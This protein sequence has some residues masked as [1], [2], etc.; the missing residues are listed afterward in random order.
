MDPELL[1]T[2]ELPE[3]ARLLIEQGEQSLDDIRAEADTEIAAIRARADQAIEQIRARADDAAGGVRQ[4]AEQAT[5]EGVRRLLERLKP[6]QAAYV[7]EG[8]LDEAL[9][10]RDRVRRLRVRLADV[11]PDPGTLAD[12]EGQQEGSSLLFE[13]TGSTDGAVWGTDIYTSDSTL[14]AAA[15]HAGALRPGEHGIV[16]V[17]FVDALNVAFQGSERNGVW[18][19]DFGEYPVGFRVARA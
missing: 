10:I 15:V 9:A 18:S 3:D 2:D 7:K 13:V 4:R 6:L 5:R 19:E 12:F 16:R 1:Q 8:K 17:T 14:S 11:R